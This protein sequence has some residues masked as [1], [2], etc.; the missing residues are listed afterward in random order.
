MVSQTEASSTRSTV[1]A[2]EAPDP[3]LS[4]V[5]CVWSHG[6][7]P[8]GMHQL[9]RAARRLCPPRRPSC[10]RSSARWAQRAR[11]RS[12]R[13]SLRPRLVLQSLAVVIERPRI[14]WKICEALLEPAPD[15]P[16]VI[17]VDAAPDFPVAQIAEAALAIMN[18]SRP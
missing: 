5:C 11:S 9:W 12:S 6:K 2:M 18:C 16:V 15:A 17:E 14:Y 1:G 7:R 13:S 4:L 8:N 10:R 3:M